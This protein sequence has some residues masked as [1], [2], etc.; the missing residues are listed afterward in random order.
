[1]RQRWS[2]MS[3]SIVTLSSDSKLICSFFRQ[4]HNCTIFYREHFLLHE[5]VHFIFV[6]LSFVPFH[7][8]SH[9][10]MYSEC[11][12]LIILCVDF[13]Q[14]MNLVLQQRH[15]VFPELWPSDFI[16]YWCVWNFWYPYFL[17]FVTFE[18]II[19]YLKVLILV[20]D[21]FYFCNRM[22][23]SINA[24]NF[25]FLCMYYLTPLLLRLC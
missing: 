1:M 11:D 14:C 19:L 10:L 4:L 13:L 5:P 12:G 25:L 6:I 3:L 15:I 2:L 8:P 20:N 9:I 7:K 21:L 22:A 17:F 24:N 23:F 18:G 16:W